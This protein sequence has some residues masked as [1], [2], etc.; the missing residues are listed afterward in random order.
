MN[1][2]FYA[3]DADDDHLL[4]ALPREEAHHL[5]RVLRLAP[6]DPV[7]VFNGRGGEFEG[8]VDRAD[9]DGASVRVGARRSA[10]AEARVAVTLAQAVLKGDKM[11]DVVRDAVMLG[12]AAIQ[13]IVTGRTEIALAALARGARRERWQRIAVSSAKQCG[14]AVVPRVLE[15]VAYQQ[16]LEAISGMSLPSPAVM[17]VEPGAAPGAL[18]ATEV[19]THPPKEATVVIGPE[20]GWTAREIEDAAASCRLVTLGGRTLRGD[21]MAVV[22]LT[23]LFTRWGEF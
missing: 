7:R 18:P 8:V 5:T 1:A 9:R 12:A 20:G 15:P 13:P 4:V 10:A 17:F 23:A 14:R 3:P 22:A 11:D 2:R 21:V 16:M 6:G 19:D